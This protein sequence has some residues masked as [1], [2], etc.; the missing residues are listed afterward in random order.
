MRCLPLAPD[1]GHGQDHALGLPG[2]LF[3]IV[4]YGEIV[5]KLVVRGLSS[6]DPHVCGDIQKGTHACVLYMSCRFHIYKGIC[7]YTYLAKKLSP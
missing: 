1:T 7:I 4:R 3:W 5:H 2:L 6:W